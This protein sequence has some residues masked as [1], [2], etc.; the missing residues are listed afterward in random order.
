MLSE[1]HTERVRSY[2]NRNTGLF[3]F[4]GKNGAT[5]NIHAS[6]WGEGVQ[7]EREASDYTNTCILREAERLDVPEP[8]LLDLGCGIGGTLQFLAARLPDSAAFRGVT[9]SARQ[10]RLARGYLTP[11]GGRV[12]ILEA[13]FH[14]LPAEWTG[15]QHLAW[16]LEAFV[17]SDRPELFLREAARVLRPG[18]RLLLIDTFPTRAAEELHPR[19]AGYIR[20]YQHCWGAGNL[21]RTDQLSALALTLGLET[22]SSLDLTPSVAKNR[23]RDRAIALLNR[24]LGPLMNRQVYLRALRGGNAVQRGFAAGWLG[25]GL[26]TF[27]KRAS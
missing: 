23:M 19:E 2:Y 6:L 4:F 10:A 25:Y 1:K 13:D 20:D 12:Q 15:S 5:R 26:L 17:H 16:A 7:S 21:L 3:N 24:A 8:R 11:F 14:A 18:G 22:L 9:L 27:E